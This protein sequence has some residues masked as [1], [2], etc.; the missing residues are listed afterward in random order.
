MDNSDGKASLKQQKSLETST[1][2]RELGPPMVE[3]SVNPKT[4]TNDQDR[5]FPS[6]I[7]RISSGQVMRN[8]G[9]YYYL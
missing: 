3:T 6:H 9:K 7:N 1:D 5:I 2:T 4:P 8:K